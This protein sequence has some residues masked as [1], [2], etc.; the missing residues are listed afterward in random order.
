[1][2]IISIRKQQASPKAIVQSQKID[3]RYREH[4]SNT[5]SLKSADFST[6]LSKIFPYPLLLTVDVTPITVDATPTYI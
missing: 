3:R 5:K 6:F 2:K 1:M 4:G